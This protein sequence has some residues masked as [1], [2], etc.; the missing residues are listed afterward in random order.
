MTKVRIT[1]TGFSTLALL[2]RYMAEFIGEEGALYLAENLIDKANKTL[3]RFPKQCPIC[4]E[5]DHIGVTDYR[6]LTADKYK[7]LY[8][9]DESTKTVYITAFMRHKQSAEELLI[10]YN[11]AK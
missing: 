3:S 9:F 6:Q 7:V 1:E 10:N 11:L 8:R 5:L 4:P 2:S